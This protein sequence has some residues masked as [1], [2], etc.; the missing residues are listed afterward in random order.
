MTESERRDEVT[1]RR[2]PAARTRKIGELEPQPYLGGT[3]QS[4]A[5]E[6]QA[7]RR[8]TTRE[9]SEIMLK[10]I[11][12]VRSFGGTIEGNVVR[13]PPQHAGISAVDWLAR[14]GYRIVWS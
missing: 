5:A 13:I 8:S 2:K 14:H 11:Q 4:V 7:R 10:C 3:V 6:E 12:T 9:A 1:A